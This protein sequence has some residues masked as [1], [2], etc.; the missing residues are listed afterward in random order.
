MVEALY[1]IDFVAIPY[2]P[3]CPLQ[4]VSSKGVKVTIKYFLRLPVMSEAVP[5][6]QAA[7]RVR[8]STATVSLSEGG[9][10]RFRRRPHQ[11]RPHMMHSAEHLRH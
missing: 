10:F 9:P 5:H 2:I 8:E 11:T 4:G 7:R 1:I 3:L 6:P